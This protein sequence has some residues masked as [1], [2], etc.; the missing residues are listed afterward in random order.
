MNTGGGGG[1][2]L[3]AQ[4]YIVWL[5]IMSNQDGH[6]KSLYSFL[7]FGR[8]LLKDVFPYFDYKKQDYSDT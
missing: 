3:G 8:S 6:I 2:G 5:M 4:A 1:R 7:F